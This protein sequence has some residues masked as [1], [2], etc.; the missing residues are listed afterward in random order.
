MKVEQAEASCAERYDVL[1]QNGKIAVMAALSGC[2]DAEST[3]CDVLAETRLEFRPLREL[4]TRYVAARPLAHAL[5]R[6]AEC[7]ELF[8][9][10]IARP[11]LDLG[12]G[13]GEFGRFA[14]QA[15]PDFG[16]DLAA[17]RLISAKRAG[18]LMS[19]ARADARRL[20]F[21][22]CS[23]A[24]VLA[25]SVL[26]HIDRP[27]EALSEA[28]RVLRPGGQFVATI[29]LADLHQHLF[30]RRWLRPLGLAGAY[31][32]AH[33]LAFNHRCLL[34]QADWDKM[35]LDAGLNIVASRKIIGPR[36]IRAFDML[37]ATAWPYRFMQAVGKHWLWRSNWARE[38]CWRFCRRLMADGDDGGQST[39]E[40]EGSALLVVAEKS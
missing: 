34:D 28:A 16:I 2:H 23:F 13:D 18:P 30:Y 35:L 21:V 14:L 40:E 36:I 19:L 29:V 31:T 38:T 39:D 11:V 33:D 37:L 17:C 3:S 1:D 12:C 4:F 10:A 5:F 26:E 24:S 6:A 25:V 8:R 15:P 20:P 7:Q 32:A 9:V 27:W 22:D